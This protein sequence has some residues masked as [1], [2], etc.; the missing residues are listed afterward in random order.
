MA[1]ERSEETKVFFFG[2]GGGAGI[3]CVQW[4]A[5]PKL[6]LLRVFRH[7]WRQSHTTVIHTTGVDSGV[8]LSLYLVERSTENDHKNCVIGC[9]RLGKVS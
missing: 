7:Q 5:P 6:C 3:V 4:L 8:R 2:G 9:N 1:P